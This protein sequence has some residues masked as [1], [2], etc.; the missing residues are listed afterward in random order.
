MF[1]C[2]I[3]YVTVE[4]LTSVNFYSLIGINVS[5]GFLSMYFI[6]SWFLILGVFAGI[7]VLGRYF[8]VPAIITAN[9]STDV[10]EAFKL[11]KKVASGYIGSFLTFLLSFAGW[12]LL[13]LFAFP[14]IFTLP[15]FLASFSEFSRTVIKINNLKAIS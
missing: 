7:V 15:Y 6:N 12:L 2:L 13:S 3:P 8:L 14:L 9:D 4:I 1:I 11:S 5:E 10:R